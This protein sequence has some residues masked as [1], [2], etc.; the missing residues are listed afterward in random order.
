VLLESDVVIHSK[1][2]E[3]RELL[4]AWF[5]AVLAPAPAMLVAKNGAAGLMYFFVACAALVAYSFRKEIA[6]EPGAEA[7]DCGWNRR[8]GSTAAALIA[9]WLFFAAFCLALRPPHDLVAAWLGLMLLIPCLCIVPYLVLATREPFAAVVF[10]ITLVVGVKLAGCVIVVAVYGWDADEFGH[11]AMPWTRPNLLVWCFFIG[12]ALLSTAFYILG[13]RK[14]QS[15]RST[16]EPK[17][18]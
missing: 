9:A 12:T 10:A 2:N 5:A 16:L 11:T 1:S 17:M 18:S 7:A 6:G 4:P 13:A 3:L 14:W 15:T 8:I